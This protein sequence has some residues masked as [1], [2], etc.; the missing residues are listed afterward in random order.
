MAIAID[1]IGES[2]QITMATA[3]LFDIR[4]NRAPILILQRIQTS[5]TPV[6]A[7]G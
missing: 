7:D 4:Q 5:I 1:P 3:C 2:I 6:I